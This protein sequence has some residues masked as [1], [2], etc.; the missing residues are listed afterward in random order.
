[1]TS[2]SIRKSDSPAIESEDEK[3]VFARVTRRILPLL[4]V[5]YMFS[6]IDRINVGFAQLQMK[7]ALHFSDAMFALG[8]GLFFV[9][10]ALF[11]VPSNLVMEKIGARKTILRIMLGWG[12]CAT[13]MAWVTTPWQFYVLR[14]FLGVFEAGFVPGV[15]LYFTYWY[16]PARRG[17]V[18]S[19]F[20]TAAI[21][22]GILVG[23]LNGAVMKFGDGFLGFHGW[24][25]MFI[26][27]GA[28]C[29]LI[30]ALVFR[31]LSDGP[32]DA[33]WLTADQK[34][35]LI[36]CLDRNRAPAQHHRRGVLWSLFRDPTVY[37]LA[38]IHMLNLAAQ[39]AMVF[40][41]PS[42]IQS[43]GVKDVFH[44]GLV[45]SIPY[46]VGGIGMVF[47]GRSSDR[48]SE[49]RGHYV[50]SLAISAGFLVAVS[51]LKGDLVPSL[52]CYSLSVIGMAASPA[53]YF[54]FV[55]EYMSKETAAA[56]IALVSCLGNLGPA[57]SPT[58]NTWI[59]TATGGDQQYSLYF[60][61]SL[62]VASGVL[63]AM[64]ARPRTALNAASQRA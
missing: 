58:V 47:I 13:M 33:K 16:P 60:I 3:M 57:I 15:I 10:Y 54:A 40:W 4:L 48:M 37:L 39:Y 19:T 56:G 9:G 20:M 7:S 31:F 14:F 32:A 6:Y 30:G 26:S 18:I 52:I 45:K 28:P 24:Q 46:I 2:I 41:A 21:V 53:L 38:V 42:M 12:A 1:M 5:A 22:A 17:R 29:L 59:L 23:P 8:A 34:R 35:L 62:F 50:F 63:M 44:L 11:E 36:D 51:M 55:S 49:R 43:W 27:N 25:W 64:A 61:V